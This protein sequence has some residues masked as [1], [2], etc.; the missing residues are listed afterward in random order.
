MSVA[1]TSNGWLHWFDR[2]DTDDAIRKAAYRA[3]TPVEDLQALP[4]ERACRAL[5]AA[6]SEIFVPGPRH[7]EILRMLVDQAKEYSLSMYPTLRDYNRRRC[8]E[9]ET[10]PEPYPILCLTG[11]AGVSKSSLIQAL[12]RICQVSP[13]SQ[14]VTDGQR[15]TVHPVRRIAVQ[16]H[17]SVRALLK[18]LSNPVAVA[19]RSMGD[20]SVLLAH[21]RDWFEATGTALLIVDEMQFYTQSG[22]AS[23]KT[24]QLIMTLASPGIPLVYA[25]NYSLVKKLLERP[26]EEKDRLLAHPIVLEPPDADSAAWCAVVGEYLAVAP[27]QFHQEVSAHAHELH[28]LTAGLF[29]V[30]RQLLLEAYR[31]AVGRS[32]K[33]VTM[34]D[35]RQAYRSG[36]FSSHRKD[37]EDLASLAVSGLIAQQRADL[38]CP[39]APARRLQ[40]P[41][42]SGR[43]TGN[44]E[45]GTVPPVAMLESTLS[46]D[47]QKTLRVLRQA[48]DNPLRPNDA[49]KV[50][51]LSRRSAVSAQTL[52][53]GAELLRGTL[54]KPK[55]SSNK[56]SPPSSEHATGK[57]RADAN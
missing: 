39:F 23:T 50:T 8:G 25:A 56:R 17:L 49:A 30:L 34:D 9:I 40:R 31:V 22:T 11:L 15:L 6:W 32:A 19:G 5:D 37:V 3:V 44:V 53:E 46:A 42:P 38:V 27:E 55:S 4:V 48:A 20:V 24:A 41:I 36:A 21:V 18:T 52:R 33:A 43:A 35:V 10:V 28:R 26:H 1:S 14:F 13:D 29:R 51:P 16:A 45:A 57:D 47:A 54:A 2:L 12:V 7:V